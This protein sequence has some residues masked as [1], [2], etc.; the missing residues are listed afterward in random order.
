[1]KITPD[2]LEIDFGHEAF[3]AQPELQSHLGYE[4]LKGLSRRPFH[5]QFVD[6]SSGRRELTSGML[7]A[8]S[9]CMARRWRK[10]LSQERVGV[11]FP[12]SLGGYIA[13]LGLVLAGKV[14]VNLNFTAGPAS[15][16]ASIAKAGIDTVITAQPVI[17][18]LDTFP[19]PAHIVDMLQERT[20]VPKPLILFWLLLVIILPAPLLARVVGVP[21]KGGNTMAALLFSSGSTG[22]PKGIVLTHRNIIGNCLQ[23]DRCKLLDPSQKLLANLPI[24]HSFGFTVNLWYALISGVRCVMLPSPLETKRCAEAIEAEQCTVMMGTA[25]F[26][27]AYFKRATREQLKSLKYVVGG[28]EK[29]PPGFHDRWQE[30]FGSEYLEGYGLSETSPV[31]GTNLPDFTRL[32][33]VDT[34]DRARRHSVG[35]L[36]PGMAARIV[37]PSTREFQ[38]ITLRGLLAL[39]GPNVFPG[40]LDDPDRTRETFKDEWLVTGDLARFDEDGFLYIE[41]RLRRFSKIAGEMVPHGTVEQAIIEA[42][43]WQEAEELPIAVT[44]IASLEKGESLVLLTTQ[45]IDPNDLRQRLKNK[46]VPNLWIPR[47]IRKV[48]A[49]P[50]LASGKLDLQGIDALAQP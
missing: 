3:E 44:G 18:K 34:P 23:I 19:W 11:V 49:I 24:F 6:R 42:F 1:M 36:F 27:R 40:Y 5:K 28:A 17:D 33:Y 47:D 4:A 22:E 30:A 35:L 16:Q 46:G 10:T 25:T 13:N 20:H 29:T 26:F 50:Q 48:E 8:V 21:R 9:I 39:K 15:V 7:L 32:D 43:D 37:N 14:P 12:S 31:V 2:N 41:G 38:D 45:E